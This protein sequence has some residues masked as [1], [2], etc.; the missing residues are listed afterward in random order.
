MKG[1]ILRLLTP[2]S[3]AAMFSS[4]SPLPSP[5]WDI[6]PFPIFF[7]PNLFS[8]TQ[9]D[10]SEVTEDTA[11]KGFLGSPS[12][13]P[14]IFFID[15]FFSIFLSSSGNNLDNIGVIKLII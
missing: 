9:W 14:I 12:T 2:R 4:P 1:W 8:V 13:N 7:L 3:H 10:S 11:A 6:P 15:L 5:P